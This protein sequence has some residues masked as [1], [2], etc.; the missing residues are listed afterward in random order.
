MVEDFESGAIS[1]WQAVGSGLEGWF[2][3][4]DGHKAPDHQGPLRVGVDNIRFQRIG[5]DADDRVALLATP[6]RPAPSISSCTG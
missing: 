6:G 5:T 2:V 4:A 1:G 3:Y